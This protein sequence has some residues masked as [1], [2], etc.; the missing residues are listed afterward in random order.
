M[1]P[2]RFQ[3]VAEETAS[4]IRSLREAAEGLAAKLTAIEADLAWE[5]LA[6]QDAGR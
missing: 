2:Q 1:A 4:A 3:Q 5:A 6:K